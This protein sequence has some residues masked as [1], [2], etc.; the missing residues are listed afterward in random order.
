MFFLLFKPDE[1]FIYPRNYSYS[2]LKRVDYTVSVATSG[3]STI[4]WA[5]SYVSFVTN[6][7]EKITKRTLLLQTKKKINLSSLTFP[8]IGKSLE[9]LTEIVKMDKFTNATRF[10]VLQILHALTCTDLFLWQ[11]CNVANMTKATHVLL[12]YVPSQFLIL[13]SSLS[14]ICCA[15]ELKHQYKQCIRQDTRLFIFGLVTITS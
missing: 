8:E 3:L 1:I 6:L 4:M 14:E 15:R 5:L 9:K 13:F 11:P 12:N 2:K 10:L 7:N